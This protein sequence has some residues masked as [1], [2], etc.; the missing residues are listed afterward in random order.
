MAL[1]AT[2]F[3]RDLEFVPSMEGHKLTFIGDAMRAARNCRLL[4]NLTRPASPVLATAGR[5]IQ[6]Q[7]E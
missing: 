5:A 4:K 6:G 1:L 2:E 7:S 3:H